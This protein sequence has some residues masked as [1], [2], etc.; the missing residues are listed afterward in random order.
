ML[1]RFAGIDVPFSKTIRINSQSP[2]SYIIP[3]YG[4][5]LTR[6]N[7]PKEH[8]SGITGDVV[9]WFNGLTVMSLERGAGYMLPMMFPITMMPCTQIRLEF[10]TDEN[11]PIELE[12]EFARPEVMSNSLTYDGCDMGV[13][14]PLRVRAIDLYKSV[15]HSL[16]IGD[17]YRAKMVSNDGSAY[18]MH[19]IQYDIAHG[20]DYEHRLEKI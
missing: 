4:D 2:G 9:M 1:K 18:T 7:I 6:I 19:P 8:R 12:Y 15:S 20:V 5:V 14:E 16:I 11:F 17:H 13:F 3:R 10:K